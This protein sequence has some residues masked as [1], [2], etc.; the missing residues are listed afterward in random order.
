MWIF[1]RRVSD[2]S[3]GGVSHTTMGTKQ[4]KVC[5][6]SSAGGD[7]PQ[8]PRRSTPARDRGDF[9]AAFGVKSG[10]KFGKNTSGGQAPYHRRIRMIQDMMGMLRQG[11][12][13]EAT[14]ELRHLRQ[15]GDSLGAMEKVCRQLTYHLSP[16]SQWKRQGIVKRKPQACLKAILAG[17][18]I[19]GSLDLSG[20]PLTMKDLERVIFYLQHNSEELENVEL[21]FTELTDEMFVHLMPVLSAL[22]HLTTLALNGNRLTKAILRE[23]TE[24][25]KDSKKFPCMTWIDLGNNV[26]IFSLPQPFLVS[27]KKRCPK[28]G[29]LPTILEFGEGQLSDLEN[30]DTSTENQDEQVTSGSDNIIHPES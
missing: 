18:P 19:E 9:W 7:S 1:S 25:L 30:Q 28:Q 27:L 12:Q 4:T 20:L 8:H 6:A 13:E 14:E 22:P 2:V 17:K 10:D 15:E 24:A 5:Q 23:I 21:C 26:D 11:R 29:N 16:H 3:P